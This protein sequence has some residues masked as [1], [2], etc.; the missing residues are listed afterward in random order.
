MSPLAEH[1]HSKIISRKSDGQYK[2]YSLENN[3]NFLGGEAVGGPGDG[4]LTSDPKQ[5]FFRPSATLHRVQSALRSTFLPALPSNQ[6]EN[7]GSSNYQLDALRSSGYLSYILNDNIQDLST[8]LRSVLATQRILEGVGVGRAGAT[9]LSATL[10]FVIRDG[11]GMVA[12]LLFTSYAAHSFRRNVKRWKY[13]ADVMVDIG[14]TLEIIAPSVLSY[15]L[16]S[17]WFL[18]LLCLGNVCKALCGVAAG[19]CGGALQMYWAVTLM[20]TEEGIS[21]I[22]AKSGAQRTVMGGLGLVLAALIANWLGSDVRTATI[23]YC[24]LTAV[25]LISN[26]RSLKLVA[27]DWLNG[28]RL[29]LVVEEFLNCVN[30]MEGNSGMKATDGSIFVSDPLQA[31]KKEPLVFLPEWRS[32]ER[33]S[34]KCPIRMGVS[35]NEFSRL[36]YQPSSFLQSRL[37]TKQSER[38]DDYILTV[39]WAEKKRCILVSYFSSSSNSEKAKTYLHACLVRHFLASTSPGGKESC[40]GEAETVQKAEETAERELV[41]LWPIFERCA[42]NAGWKLG[43]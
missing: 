39:G 37:M 11:C 1:A 42:T 26:Y 16:L 28:W 40:D 12:S 15:P 41:R 5:K 27:L 22:A 17:R 30:D 43:K 23:L 21:E 31:S 24:A 38:K 9:A 13:F 7:N 4:E 25:H 29:H 35:F 34:S 8:S 20:G 2:T 19:A 10:N 36:S 14:I 3:N 18:P 6:G 32:M 33:Q